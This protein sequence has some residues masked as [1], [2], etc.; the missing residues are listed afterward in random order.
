MNSLSVA[1]RLLRLFKFSAQLEI[2]LM[3]RVVARNG[4]NY[5]NSTYL[6]IVKLSVKLDSWIEVLQTL[7]GA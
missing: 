6:P 7:P 4:Y 2:A 3:V 5:T 1:H